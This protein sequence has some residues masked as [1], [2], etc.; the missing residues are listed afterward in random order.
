MLQDP[1]VQTILWAIAAALLVGYL[2]KRRAR[3]GREE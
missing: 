3:L 2:A 1:T